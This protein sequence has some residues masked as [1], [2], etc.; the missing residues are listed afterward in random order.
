MQNL[1]PNANF[2]QKQFT[3]TAKANRKRRQ[4]TTT[5]NYRQP[6]H[7]NDI[8]NHGHT[9]QST[10]RNARHY[11]YTRNRPRSNVTNTKPEILSPSVVTNNRYQIL[12]KTLD[13]TP[14]TIDSSTPNINDIA[15]TKI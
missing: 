9:R 14:E 4:S 3:T 5:E 6:E 15:T 1:Q 13:S 7:P 8:G 11:N 10:R 2:R 12:Q